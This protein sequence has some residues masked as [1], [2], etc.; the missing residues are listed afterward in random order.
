MSEE[1]LS[2]NIYAILEEALIELKQA[3]MSQ[4]ESQ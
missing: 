4:E 3:K 2:A 1:Q